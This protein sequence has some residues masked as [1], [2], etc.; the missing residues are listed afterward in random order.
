MILI[1]TITLL[2]EGVSTSMEITDIVISVLF[3]LTT[4]TFIMSVFSGTR[5]VEISPQREAAIATG[6]DDRKTIFENQLL[7]PFMWVILSLATKLNIPG[8]RNHIN[9]QLIASGNPDLFTPEEYLA[10]SMFYGFVLGIMFQVSSTLIEGTLGV[11][12]FFAGMILGISMSIFQLYSNASKRLR[13][14]TRQLPFSL[15]LISLSMGAGATFTEAVKTIV[16]EDEQNSLNQEFRALLSEMDLGTTRAQA[17]VN[18]ANR[19]PLDSVRMIV[20]SVKQAEALG[21]PLAYVLK[22]QATL[23]RRQRTIRA[24]NLAASASIKILVPCL[25]LVMAVIL[26]IFGP[27]IVRIINEGMF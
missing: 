15:E 27:W 24:E 10:V 19:I 7:R 14:I 17:L 11:M 20:A 26:T 5:V 18:M 1:S 2:A 12:W 4:V 25:L 3:F 21:T 9:S 13:N 23:L 16:Q 8:L 22:D 6:H